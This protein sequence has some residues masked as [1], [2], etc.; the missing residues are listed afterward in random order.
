MDAFSE[1]NI[2]LLTEE[3]RQLE[4]N[5]KIESISLSLT[6]ETAAAWFIFYNKNWPQVQELELLIESV[7]QDEWGPGTSVQFDRNDVLIL[8]SN[9]DGRQRVLQSQHTMNSRIGI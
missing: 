4:L 2:K 6:E 1:K 5:K 8:V 9:V 3:N 7:A